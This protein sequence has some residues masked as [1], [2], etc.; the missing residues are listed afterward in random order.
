MMN[1]FQQLWERV[2][3]P[4]QPL[5]AGIY[6]YQAP[7]D[8]PFHYRLHLRVEPEGNGI[9]IV[10]ASTVVHLN[11]T[12]TEYAYHLVQNTNEDLAVQEIA[13]RY[14]VRKEIVK[15]DYADLIQRLNSLID[16]PDLDPVAFLDFQ[17]EE[18]YSGT[19]SAPYRLDCALTYRL[20]DEQLGRYAPLDR[21]SRE[22]S[23]EE[24]KAILDKACGAGIPHVIFTGGEPTL[25]PDVPELISHAEKLEMVSGLITNGMRLSE[26]KYL[27]ELLQSGLDHILILMNPSEDQAWEAVRDTL[28]EDIALTV[29]LTLTRR[30]LPNFEKTLDRL[31]HMGVKNLSLSAESLD[32]K[33]ELQARRQAAAERQMHMVWD[34]PVPYS[35]FHP[36]ALELAETIPDVNIVSTGA[37]NA[38]LYV[39]P[40]GDVLPGQGN[41]H[42]VLG[43]LLTDPWEKIWQNPHR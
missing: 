23:S 15:R 28:A 18:P 34:L 33:D 35:Q 8:A 25:R 6:H 4:V 2:F 3:P 27:N 16:T 20:P 38:W 14:N 30:D 41:F 13:Q 43:N 42:K 11:R 22:L 26:R 12:A 39:E 10:N 32:L 21:V 5:P 1:L 19:I 37:G 24:W 31:A 29:H 40:D 9:L 36:V 7:A 17:R